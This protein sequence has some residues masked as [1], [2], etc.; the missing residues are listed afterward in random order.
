[1][2]V[3][4]D[5]MLL[6]QTEQGHTIHLE[7]PCDIEKTTS[8]PTKGVKHLFLPFEKPKTVKKWWARVSIIGHWTA[9]NRTFGIETVKCCHTSNAQLTPSWTFSIDCTA[10]FRCSPRL[11]LLSTVTITNVIL[12]RRTCHFGILSNVTLTQPSF[13]NNVIWTQMSNFLQEPFANRL[14]LKVGKS[15]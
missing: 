8:K 1:M 13:T 5:G 12:T 14:S 10:T 3:K 2:A 11:T 9:N 7:K 15:R 4:F 6:W